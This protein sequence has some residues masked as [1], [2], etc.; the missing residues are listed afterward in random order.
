MSPTNP[1]TDPPGA[2]PGI[3][4]DAPADRQYLPPWI[5]SY[6]IGIAGISGS[7]KTSV[8]SQIIKKLNVCFILNTSFDININF[9]DFFFNSNHG[10]FFY[11]W[12]TIIIR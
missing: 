2:S 1:P 7:G 10:R 3:S 9:Y 8:A 6:I 4:S 5:G 11:Q 12:T